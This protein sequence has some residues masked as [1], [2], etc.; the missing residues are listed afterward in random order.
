[1]RKSDIWNVSGCNYKHL[2]GHSTG[3]KSNQIGFK[4]PKRY[5]NGSGWICVNEHVWSVVV[6][7]V[8]LECSAVAWKSCGTVQSH[9][10][11][12]FGFRYLLTQNVVSG[13]RRMSRNCLVELWA[14]T[15]LNS[16]EYPFIGRMTQI[17]SKRQKS[18][19]NLILQYQKA[20]KPTLNHSLH[21]WAPKSSNNS[22]AF[23]QNHF[24]STNCSTLRILCD[25]YCVVNPFKLHFQV[26]TCEFLFEIVRHV[27]E[28]LI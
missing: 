13:H 15:I 4:L 1:M 26:C 5:V 17:E 9:F 10:W 14:T 20:R 11:T 8:S 28:R 27:N 19:F 7:T 6:L 24:L 23:I 25:E 18:A 21:L 12:D 16:S 22:E 3:F 2:F